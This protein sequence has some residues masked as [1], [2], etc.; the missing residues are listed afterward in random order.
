MFVTVNEITSEE[1]TKG[2][3]T[4]HGLKRLKL[5]PLKHITELMAKG[6]TTVED[7]E[8]LTEQLNNCMS[9]QINQ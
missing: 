5:V 3:M 1:N 7:I 4:E 2:S 8:N 6:I 9:T